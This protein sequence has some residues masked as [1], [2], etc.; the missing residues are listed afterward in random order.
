MKP[1]IQTTFILFFIGTIIM[2]VNSLIT[3]EKYKERLEQKES[4]YKELNTL[5]LWYEHE[6]LKD[7]Y[8]IP[9]DSIELRMPPE[10]QN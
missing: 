5:F 6:Y 2:L 9:K 4:E 3:I 8:D 1:F 10:Y 7:I